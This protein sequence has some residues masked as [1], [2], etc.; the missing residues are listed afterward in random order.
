MLTSPWNTATVPS[1]SLPGRFLA[2]GYSISCAYRAVIVHSYQRLTSFPMDWS[3]S[4]SRLIENAGIIHTTLAPIRLTR[5]QLTRLFLA[6]LNR[7]L[8]SSMAGLSST[9]TGKYSR[10]VENVGI[11]RKTLA[12]IRLSRMQLMG[13]LLAQFWRDRGAAARITLVLLIGLISAIVLDRLI[14]PETLEA[15]GLPLGGSSTRTKVDFQTMLEAC[16]SKVILL[17]YLLAQY[18]QVG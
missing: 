9:M 16:K 13:L 17:S 12:P 15:L 14:R 10:F 4:Y 8:L 7:D 18:M 6:Q 3:K 11:I 5:L 1:P 2:Q